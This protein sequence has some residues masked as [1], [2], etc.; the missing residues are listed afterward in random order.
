MASTLC[1]QCT[2]ALH[3]ER[4]VLTVRWTFVQ[5][6]ETDRFYWRDGWGIYL[7]GFCITV[8]ACL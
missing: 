3:M 6:K 8:L 2:D 4:K 5:G 7:T 1:I